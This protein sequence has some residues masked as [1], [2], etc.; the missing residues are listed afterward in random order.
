MSMSE[1]TPRGNPK[2]GRIAISISEMELGK[3]VSRIGPRMH[4]GV[5][6]KGFGGNM[7]ENIKRMSGN[8]V[9][10]VRDDSNTVPGIWSLV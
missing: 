5:K 1:M 7:G 9:G 4:K 10:K 8:G 6:G 3:A 2:F